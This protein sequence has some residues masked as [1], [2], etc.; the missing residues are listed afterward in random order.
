[1][2]PFEDINENTIITKESKIE[3]WVEVNGRKKNTYVSGWN[4]TKDQLK[5][6]LTTI[7]KKNGCNG[8]I[9]DI[10][11]S[12]GTELITVM[13][14]QGDHSNYMFDYL[15]GQQVDSTSISVKG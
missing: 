2:N 13:Q 9:K 14:F 7:K 10:S 12:S 6:H 11:N 5:E 1:M 4:I 8:T 3:I 15:I